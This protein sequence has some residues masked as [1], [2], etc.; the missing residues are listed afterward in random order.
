MACG[1]ACLMVQNRAV[2]SAGSAVAFR[3][4][5]LSDVGAVVDLVQSAYRG[6]ASR[7]G[8]TTE[9]DLLDGSRIDPNTVREVVS[10]PRSVVM[11]AYQKPAVHRTIL[12]DQGGTGVAAIGELSACCQLADE[13]GG[14]GYFGLFAVRPDRQGTGIGRAVLAEA[15]RRVVTDWRCRVLRMLVIR[16]R[17][18][19]IAW[20]V[21]LGFALTGGKSPFPYGDERFGRPKR[22]DLEFVELRKPLGEIL[23]PLRE[24]P[25]FLLPGL[26]EQGKIEVPV[27]DL[28]DSVIGA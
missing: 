1:C 19:L 7:V 16:Q 2:L 25:K 12:A 5:T 23:S 22:P 13:G 14:T 6:E 9:A 4:A 11:L 20:Y 28:R 26:L 8:W 21:R 10:A 27:N 15:E 24:R 3:D 17:T 18:D